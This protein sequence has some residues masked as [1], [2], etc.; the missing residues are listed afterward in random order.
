MNAVE[1]NQG[2][3]ES[4]KVEEASPLAVQQHTHPASPT[5]ATT[6]E[7]LGVNAGDKNATKAGDHEPEYE[8]G[9]GFGIGELVQWKLGGFSCWPGR[10]VSWWMTGRSRAAEGTRWVMWFGDGKF[11]VMCEEEKNP[12]KEV[13]TDM[14]VE[15]EAAAHAPPPPAKKPRKSTTEK[16]KVKEIIDERP[17]EWLVYEVRQKCRNVEDICISCG[18]L[19]V[20]LEHPLFI[21]GVYQNCEN[22]FLEC[23][24]QYDDGYQSF[25]TICCGGRELLMGGNSNCCRCFCV[26]CVDLLV[27]PGAAQGAIKEDPWNC[28]HKGT[29]ALLRRRDDWPSWLQMLFANNHD[30]EF[31]PPKV[32]PPVPAENGKPIRVLSLRTLHQ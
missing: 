22:C 17:R 4:Q 7:P 10:I 26:E 11:S 16:L 30:R 31:D 8:D 5:A 32:Y 29:Y 23:A 1:E 14:W 19:N 3:G 27:G 18:S 6:P 12:Y 24:Y 28:G 9:Q 25:C 21:G 20:T 2:P 15:S 13:Y